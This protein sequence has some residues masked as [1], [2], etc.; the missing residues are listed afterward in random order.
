MVSHIQAP[1]QKIL[2]EGQEAFGRGEFTSGR[3]LFTRALSLAHE[4]SAAEEDIGGVFFA[5]G[6]CL[7]AS[8]DSLE[9]RQRLNQALRT[10]ER[11]VGADS[12]KALQVKSELAALDPSTAPINAPVQQ[13]ASQTDPESAAPP[14]AEG[15]ITQGGLGRFIKT[16]TKGFDPTYDQIMA[17]RQPKKV[18]PIDVDDFV[19]PRE[20]LY[21]FWT[22][23]MGVWLYSILALCLVG[24]A[25][26]PLALLAGFISAGIH[27]GHL[28]SRGIKVSERQFPEIFN[29]IDQYSTALNM[30]P[31]EV[32]VVQEHGLLNAFANR[33]HRK[34]MI[35]IY[36]DV[37][38]LAYEMGEKEM[39]F[40]V[41]HELAHIKRQHVKMAWLHMPGDL[42]PFLGGAYS[43]ACEYT[44]DRVAAE[45]VPD[46]ALFGLV[47]LAAGTKLYKRINIKALYEQA[48]EEWGFWTW[49]SE[50]QSTHPNLM[51]RIRAIGLRDQAIKGFKAA[52]QNQVG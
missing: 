11:S 46:G 2:E 31:P 18:E 7:V 14:V 49:F 36:S 32:Y 1:W 23:A 19:H 21:G 15:R 4:E 22:A 50:V 45:I 40:V 10:Y 29:M 5:F 9:G 26:A 52:A 24:F 44:C 37:V 20:K 47:C 51:N 33:L 38:E 25:L 27:L 12:D 17:G 43:R 39:A 28:R 6:R 3:D 48:E 34:D 8:G 30:Q 42:V 13:K 35:V 41:C 16:S